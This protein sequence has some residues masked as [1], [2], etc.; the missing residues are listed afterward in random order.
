MMS[1]SPCDLEFLLHCYYCPAVYER[2]NAP[3]IQ[4]ARDYFLA[5]DIIKPVPNELFFTTT[6]KGKFWINEILKTPMPVQKWVSGKQKEP[7]T[8]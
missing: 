4:E 2:I 7:V 3:A 1:L 8:E 6:E 5:N